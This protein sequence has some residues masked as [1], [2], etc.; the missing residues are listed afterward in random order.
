M[1]LKKK[2]RGKQFPIQYLINFPRALYPV[3][4][5]RTQ[6]VPLFAIITFFKAHFESQ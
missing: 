5:I 4:T 3:R 6:I 2:E 1:F